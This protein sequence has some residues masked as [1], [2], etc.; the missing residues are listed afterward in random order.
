MARSSPDPLDFRPLS[1]ALMRTLMGLRRFWFHPQFFG[2]EHLDPQ[3]PALYVGNHTLYG[4]LDAPL[5]V[6]GVYEHTGIYLRAL[7]DHFHF[8][9]P[10]WGR[11]VTAFG[12]VDG[13]PENCSK[14]M[15]AGAHFIVYPGG[16]RE[17][18]KNR[19]EEYRLVW[20][21]RTGFARM[22][23]QH[24]YDIIPFA[25]LGADDVFRIRYDS[26]TFRRSLPGKLAQR[27]GLLD[28]WFRGGDT[29]MPLA[30]GIAGLPL[31]RP[32]KMYFMFGERI[33]T[34]HLQAAAGNRQAQWQVRQQVEE[35]IYRQLDELFAIR[36]KDRD[37][38]WWRRKLIARP[39]QS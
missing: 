39:G 37:W 5:M 31:P 18:M 25:A 19:G 36:A 14:L 29:V 13:T 16:A 7:G 3:R 30:T 1:P 6:Q 10:G 24:G 22:A 34:R 4:L 32:E 26:K 21:N 2:L 17:V 33:P 11:L 9:T 8:V 27:S 15:Q 35:A 28:R 38:P 12:A 20:K 23:M